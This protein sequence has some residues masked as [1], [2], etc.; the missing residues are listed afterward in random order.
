MYLEDVTDWWILGWIKESDLHEVTEWYQCKKFQQIF[1]KNCLSEKTCKCTG[2][3]SVG[4]SDMEVSDME[5]KD[6]F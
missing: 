6:Q 5:A 1:I 4:V 2:R 3:R